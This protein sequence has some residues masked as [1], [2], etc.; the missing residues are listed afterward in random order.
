MNP[1]EQQLRTFITENFFVEDADLRGEISLTRSGIIDST[2][3]MEILLFLEERFGIKV[4]DDE[5]TPENLDTLD[6]LVRY[7]GQAENRVSA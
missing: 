1:V 2:G 3:V 4:P 6:N 5:I 7:V